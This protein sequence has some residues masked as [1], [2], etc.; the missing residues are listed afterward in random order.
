M[1]AAGTSVPPRS[2]DVYKRQHGDPGFEHAPEKEELEAEQG[3]GGRHD[4][5][6]GPAPEPGQLPPER[7]PE[8]QGQADVYKRQASVP[9][10]ARYAAS[11][12]DSR[13]GLAAFPEVRPVLF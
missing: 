3:E 6:H 9:E 5:A 2:R 12:P 13:M 7:A 4:A 8:E 1:S 11:G 10:T